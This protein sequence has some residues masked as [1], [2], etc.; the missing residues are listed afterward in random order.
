TKPTKTMTL[1]E[2]VTEFTLTSV[3][4][5]HQ[6]PVCIPFY[7]KYTNPHFSAGICSHIFLLFSQQVS[8]L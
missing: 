2:I 4:K 5:I 6:L 8:V 7:G 1:D 3:W